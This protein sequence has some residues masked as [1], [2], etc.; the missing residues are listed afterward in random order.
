M[1]SA[2]PACPTANGGTP[3]V[4]VSVKDGEQA[5][6]PQILPGGETVLFTLATGT[7]AERWDQAQIVTHSLRSGER[8]TLVDGGSDGRYVPTGH[9]V[10]AV[11][12]IVF[13]VPMDLRRLEVTGGAVP[14]VEGVRRGNNITGAAQFDFS[15]AGSHRPE[16]RC[17]AAEPPT[18]PVPA[19]SRR[20]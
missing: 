9:L 15:S 13:A 16:G 17:G 12:G 14:I 3:E 7:A 5:Y 20:S 4:L 8:K 19:S 2:A 1:P 18:G 6:G 10:Y 11:G